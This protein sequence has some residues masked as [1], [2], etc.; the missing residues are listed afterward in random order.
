MFETIVRMSVLLMNDN[1][2]D[3]GA[4][5]AGDSGLADCGGVTN[6]SAR[7]WVAES[8]NWRY[9]VGGGASCS[10]YSRSTVTKSCPGLPGGPGRLP[11]Q[12]RRS[13]KERHWD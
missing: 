3:N 1:D 5:D 6:R 4:D 10:G 8:S 7:Q 11:R 9:A 12:D 13:H 2:D